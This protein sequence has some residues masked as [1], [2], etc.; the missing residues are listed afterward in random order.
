MP[1]VGKIIAAHNSK[2]LSTETSTTV[3][4]RS[5]NCRQPKDCPLNGR[6][7]SSCVVYKA[8]VTAPG[9]P[10]KAYYGL[11]EGAFKTR[12]ANHQTSFNRE[13]HIKDTELSKYVWDLREQG[14]VG[15]V[16]WEIA[17]RAYPYKCGSRKCDL[18]LTEKLAIASADP[19]S[20]LN[21][22]SEIISTCRHRRKYS[23][24]RL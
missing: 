9:K 6:C 11:T 22:R 4:P 19:T 2:T 14:L 10:T 1:N 7:M 20:L 12:Y 8:T 5:C 3:Q 23:C 17:K 21:K 15:K 24:T 18:C 16:Q 13:T